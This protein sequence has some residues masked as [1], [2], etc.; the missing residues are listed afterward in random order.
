MPPSSRQTARYTGPTC[1]GSRPGDPDPPHLDPPDH[2]GRL[3][4]GR[5]TGAVGR[6]LC[7]VLL[8]SGLF[9]SPHLKYITC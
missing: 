6:Q 5:G 2:G 4:A 7:G 8:D 9:L 3:S 1:S